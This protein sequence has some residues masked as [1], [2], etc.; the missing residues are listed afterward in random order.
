MII[1]SLSIESKSNSFIDLIK[2][3]KQSRET[4]S[5]KPKV[6]PDESIHFND[7][8]EDL[9]I[10][11]C[12]DGGIL[13]TSKVISSRPQY[14]SKSNITGDTAIELKQIIFGSSTQCFNKEWQEQG[15]IFNECPK[16]SYGLIQH[17]GGPCGLLAS[18]QGYILKYLLFKGK[19]RLGRFFK[20]LSLF[21]KS[22][23]C[24]HV[25][26]NIQSFMVMIFVAYFLFFPA[27]ERG[28]S[29]ETNLQFFKG[30][31]RQLLCFSFLLFLFY[32][33]FHLPHF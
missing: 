9:Q 11:E 17:K 6:C 29:A 5:S 2:V 12:D 13:D 7:N 16:L 19:K 4:G 32:L 20:Y 30:I 33:T 3:K 10:D 22:L 31:H 14:T 23:Y 26:P 15:F 21:F 24:F 18:V 25:I 1:N 8:L 28:F 27:L